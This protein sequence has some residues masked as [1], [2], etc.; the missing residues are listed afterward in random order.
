MIPL[1]SFIAAADVLVVENARSFDINEWEEW[2]QQEIDEALNEKH[3]PIVKNEFEKYVFDKEAVEE[4]IK[5][6]KT[7]TFAITDY[8]KTLQFLKKND[9]TKKDL[10]DIIRNL[11]PGD[12]RINSKSNYNEAIIFIRRSKINDLGPFKLYIKLDYDS[13]E[14]QPVIVISFHNA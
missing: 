4:I 9:L 7:S 12:Y 5:K 11:E 13:I 10:E 2:V 3:T 1:K 8:W 6:L 14:K